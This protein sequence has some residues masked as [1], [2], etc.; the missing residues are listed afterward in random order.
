VSF[1]TATRVL[2]F[3]RANG[4]CEACGLPILG[5]AQDHHRRPRGMGGSSDPFTDGAA[6]GLRVHP[7]CHEGIERNRTWALE[8]GL[9]LSQWQVP[10]EHRVKLWS[11]WALLGDDGTLVHIKDNRT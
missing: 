3:K 8:R 4:K 1:S 7:G 9:L 11:G 2:I 5:A 10:S 6:N